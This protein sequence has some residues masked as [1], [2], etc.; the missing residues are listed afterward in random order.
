MQNYILIAYHAQQA[1]NWQPLDHNS[2]T[3][4]RQIFGPVSKTKMLLQLHRASLF[5]ITFLDR[6]LIK[7]Y[8]SFM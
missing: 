7:S 2:L 6:T 1:V 8:V 3:T 5:N 4:K